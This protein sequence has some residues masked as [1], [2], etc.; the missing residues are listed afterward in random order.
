ML[1]LPSLSFQL[2]PIDTC[3]G[4]PSNEISVMSKAAPLNRSQDEDTVRM[5]FRIEMK[6]RSLLD[7]AFDLQPEPHGRPRHGST[8]AI[9]VCWP[10]D[11]KI[12]RKQAMMMHTLD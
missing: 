12:Q 1:N 3:G 10:D 8:L 6:D 9:K 11:G 2:L 7:A 5:Y 4:L